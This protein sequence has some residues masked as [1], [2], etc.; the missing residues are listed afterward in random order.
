MSS[1][2]DGEL[3]VDNRC[4][5]EGIHR[6]ATI[7]CVHCKSLVV[8]RPER[9][10]ERAQCHLCS[11][12]Y[13][14]DSCDYERSLPTYNHRSFEQLSDMVRSGR[15]TIV[16]GTTSAPVLVNNSTGVLQYGR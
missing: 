1:K 3:E 5:G 9:T 8:K 2:F 10:R 12:Q 16:G 15:W 6:T 13:I 7:T 11:S 14:C 4:S